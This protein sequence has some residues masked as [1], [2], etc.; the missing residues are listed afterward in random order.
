MQYYLQLC[1]DPG[2]ALWVLMYGYL[3]TDQSFGCRACRGTAGALLSY[4]EAE[5]GNSKLSQF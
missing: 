1:L 3:Q 4:L 5:K 2:C